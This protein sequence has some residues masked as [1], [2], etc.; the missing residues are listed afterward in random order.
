MHAASQQQ[1]IEALI[2][3]L[4]P[5]V[6]RAVV[7]DPH[8]PHAP[9]SSTFAAA[10]LFAD[11][12]G[13][14][15][16]TETLAVRGPEGAEELMLLLNR[17]FSRMIELLVAE[18]GEVVQFSGDALLAVFPTTTTLTEVVQA[19]W[20]A[21]TRMQLAMIEF[22]MIETS[23]GP[24]QLG[25][26][27]GIGVGDV[28]GMSVG[29]ELGRWQYI[30]AG[31]PLR[32]VAEAEHRA[33][34][35]DVIVSAE[36]LAL[37]GD[38]DLHAMRTGLPIS[39]PVA[40]FSEALAAGLFTHIPGAVKARLR[41][42][43]ADWLGELRQMS[44][45]FLGI[46]NPNDVQPIMLDWFHTA[47]RNLQAI[48]YRYEGSLNKLLVDDKG[49]IGIILFGAPP[50]A[51]SDDPLRAVR[52]A[53]DLQ[54]QAAVLGQRLAIGVTSG[55]VFAG[56]VGSPLRR[57]YTVIGD[58]VNLAARLMHLAGRGG[59][60]T[61]HAT[62]RATRNE[63]NWEALP[64]QTVK[65]K[66]VPVR[67][68]RPLST[69]HGRRSI[70]PKQR[71]VGR[72]IEVQQLTDALDQA[73]NNL[74]IVCLEGEPGIGKSRLV[75]E[76]TQLIRERGAI[77]LLGGGDI[78]AQEI[79]YQAWRAILE[80]YFDIE[81]V[82][83]AE[84]RQ[85]QII[86]YVKANAPMLLPRLSLLNDIL[87]IA[88]PEEP[89][90]ALLKPRL[91]Q[92][93][94]QTLVI[95]LLSVWISE[96][97]LVL[98]FED[99]H[100][101][102]SLS[103]QLLL[104]VARTFYDQPL[105]L[106]LALRPLEN[107]TSDHPYRQLL[108]MAYV[109]YLQ[110]GPLSSTE[111]ALLVASE[112]GVAALPEPLYQLAAQR[113][114][115]PFV[116]EA[117]AASLLET[118]A[119]TVVDGV[120][121]LRDQLGELRLP[122]TVHGL[123]LTRLDRLSANEQLTMK[124]ASVF[125][126][127]F[128]ENALVDVYPDLAQRSTV[129]EHL[130]TL[131]QRELFS[132]VEDADL[133]RTH[134]FR[135][136]IVQDVT[137]N[138]LLLSQRQDLHAQVARWYER[139][140]GGHPGDL[141]TL[142]AYHWR[143]A[144]HYERELVYTEMAARLLVNEYAN[145]EAIRLLSRALALVN[146]PA[147]EYE[148]RWLRMEVY[149]R[150]GDRAA[151]AAE[152]E[153]LQR[154]ANQLADARRQAW[155]ANAWAAYQR[156]LSNYSAALIALAQARDLARQ[157]GDLAS[158]AYSLMISGQVNEYQGAYAEARL[159]FEQA[160]ALYRQIGDQRGESKMLSLLG[161]IHYYLGEYDA[162][163]ASDRQALAICRTIGD[164]GREA[165]ILNNLGQV[166]LQV[167]ALETAATF[168]AEAL[169]SARL[170]GDRSTEAQTLNT[171]GYLGLSR[172]D[173]AAARQSLE[174][175]VR[176]ARALSMRRLEANA[177]NALGQIWRDVGDYEQARQAFEQA[178]VI[179]EA[180]GDDSMITYNYLNLGYVLRQREPT[181]S[182]QLYQQALHLAQTT[183]N[184]DAEAYA[185]SYAAAL[186]EEQ[187]QWL[188]AGELYQMALPIRHEIQS[189][190]ARVEDQAGLARVALA[191]HDLETALTLAE[192]CFEYLAASGSDGMEFP[193]LVY[194]TCYQVLSAGGRANAVEI[195][196]QAVQLLRSRAEA[197]GD[198]QLRAGFLEQVAVHRQV[199]A[200]YAQVVAVLQP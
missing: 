176:L 111:A 145:A 18:G 81:S 89:L 184:R 177:L 96:H 199:L 146:D 115:N 31:D 181:R 193:L 15:A 175:A 154:L 65:G 130:L 58:I 91:R 192:V 4:P 119:V 189:L 50:M 113:A 21:A 87:N 48:V 118:G 39:I 11:V 93:S 26:K 170:I 78:V 128:G 190:A 108:S 46:A 90:V 156:D 162:A 85:R 172:G 68:Y 2:S 121:E 144:G 74:Q 17:Y 6:V 166:E 10:V 105:L 138:T 104:Q 88:F 55:Q 43:Q 168:L 95:H 103:W 56:P 51:H 34:R 66:A 112:L 163:L 171:I 53:L 24:V 198:P 179:L 141:A 123:V 35:G 42:G 7:A 155:V 62:Y 132:R 160:I 64:L 110:L 107:P 114:T 92:E 135:Q 67:V 109:H 97:P 28:I 44:V 131:V 187:A 71:L 80:S 137:Y 57:E 139:W 9:T 16:L 63:L 143:Q 148:L 86:Q 20:R 102:D 159:M 37:L 129:P 79:P 158:E 33:Q 134:S 52:C 122:E 188:L 126:V 40:P 117:L 196:E 124:T 22:R 5:A 182:Q 32:Q 72:S 152:L 49:T 19:A 173:Y 98:V 12:S 136:I 140:V 25:M 116:A 178:I 183:G 69:Q 197:I 13:F 142:L 1:L 164:R 83:S 194:L 36:A 167:G 94:L 3:F 82:T 47:L 75:A 151:Q 165:P 41:A 100:A 77:G 153:Q 191:Q 195:L 185:L 169:Q 70:E 174:L 59:V 8:A 157:Q 127:S 186:A 76:L 106:A 147:H 60:Y 14:T 73:T 161:N 30:V 101:L 200:L 61:D 149:E 45:L 27:I 23:A 99:A 120:C 180:V 125:G 38:P 133:L 84:A 54:A 150:V 29:G